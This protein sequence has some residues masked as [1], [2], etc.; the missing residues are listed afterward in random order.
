MAA[1]SGTACY[2]IRS[3][4]FARDNPQSD[5]MQYKGETTCEPASRFQVQ[6]ADATRK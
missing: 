3:Y 2:S 6:G 1:P 5:V 4:W